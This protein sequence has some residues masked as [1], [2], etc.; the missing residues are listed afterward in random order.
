[1]A[2]GIILTDSERIEGFRV[3]FIQKAWNDSERVVLQA[4]PEEEVSQKMH[5]T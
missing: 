5:V 3:S 1:M 4:V 2:T